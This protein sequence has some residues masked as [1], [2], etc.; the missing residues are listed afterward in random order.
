MIFSGLTSKPVAQVSQF[1]PQNWQVQFGDLGRKITVMVS[2]FGSQTKRILVY[3]LRH[4]TDV[5]RTVWDM[6]RDLAACFV[7]KQ[8]ALGFPSLASRLAEARR[9]VVHVAPS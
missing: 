4:K 5:G 1:V 8:V 3:R 7:W 2:W 9:W 6:R